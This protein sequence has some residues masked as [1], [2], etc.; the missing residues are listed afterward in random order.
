MAQTITTGGA[1]RTLGLAA[2]SGATLASLYVAALWM[3]AI[4]LRLVVQP[5][6][7]YIRFHP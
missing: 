6:A 3:G 7:G 5:L 2:C 4:E 1:L